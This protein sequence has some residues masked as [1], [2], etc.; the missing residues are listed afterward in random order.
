MTLGNSSVKSWKASMIC[1]RVFV[2]LKSLL[3]LPSL[4]RIPSIRKPK[5]AVDDIVSL[6]TMYLE[7]NDNMITTGKCCTRGARLLAIALQLSNHFRHQKDPE[8]DSEN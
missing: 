3:D 2:V 8:S 7:Q 4:L 5:V 6:H 1:W